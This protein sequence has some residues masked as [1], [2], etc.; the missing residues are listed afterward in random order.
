VGRAGDADRLVPFIVLHKLHTPTL[1]RHSPTA[2]SRTAE[3]M[4]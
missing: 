1:C 4:Q 3:L 2:K